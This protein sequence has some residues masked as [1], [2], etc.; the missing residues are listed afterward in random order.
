M[1][2]HGCKSCGVRTCNGRCESIDQARLLFVLEKEGL[3][4]E[5]YKMLQDIRLVLRSSYT[6]ALYPAGMEL[7]KQLDIVHARLR[8]ITKQLY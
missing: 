2:I 6:K 4:L 7:K 5:D 3:T 8:C 1:S